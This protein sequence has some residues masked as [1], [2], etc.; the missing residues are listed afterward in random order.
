M[1]DENEEELEPYLVKTFHRLLASSL[2]RKEITKEVYEELVFLDLENFDQLAAAYLRFHD[3]IDGR[4]QI[5]RR[6]QK[7][8]EMI[9]NETDPI[10]R[11]QYAKVYDALCAEL[12]RMGGKT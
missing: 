9:D 3:E 4:H 10:Q 1:S 8:A 6:I 7:G 5:L 12:E 2:S 11:A